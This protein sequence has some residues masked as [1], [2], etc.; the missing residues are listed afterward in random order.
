MTDKIIVIV[1]NDFV[2]L[3]AAVPRCAGVLVA[4]VQAGHLSA[5]LLRRII[6][7][8]SI[9]QKKDWCSNAGQRF[10]LQVQNLNDATECRSTALR[11]D[12]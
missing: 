2:C 8:S 6:V 9:P 4:I 7:T 11:R 5:L 1:I 3:F 12:R 10:V